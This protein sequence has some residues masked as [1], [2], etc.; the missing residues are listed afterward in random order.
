MTDKNRSIPQPDIAPPVTHPTVPKNRLPSGSCDS[1]AHIFGPADRYPYVSPRGYTPHNASLDDYA[2]LLR[3][4]G[5]DRAVLVQPSVY[6]TDN[7]LMADALART[8]EDSLGIAWRGIAVLDDS[9]TDSELERLHDLGVRGLR[10]N[11]LFQG[12][13]VGFD[14]GARLAN[15]IAP[16]GWHLQFLINIASFEDFAGRLS[17]LPVESVIDHIGHFPAING[18]DLPQFADL[19][20]LMREGRSWVKLSGPN[21]IS[22]HDAAPFTDAQ[23]LAEDLISHVPD[24]LVFGTDWPHVQLSTSMP[25]DGV[26]VDEL[27]RW[28]GGDQAMAKRILVNNPERLYSF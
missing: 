28:C 1:H 17:R 25:D 6:G 10:L 27:Y 20:A 21:R 2:G 9:V 7:R 22:R 8:R 13:E 19:K 26:L 3:H 4:L 18:P 16:L 11:L 12:A 5:F 14:E 23:R 15:R 24:R